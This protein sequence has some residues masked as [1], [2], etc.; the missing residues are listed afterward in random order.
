MVIDLTGS[1]EES[2]ATNSPT[3][4]SNTRM[5]EARPTNDEGNND[6][7]DPTNPNTA[8]IP[9]SNV[10]QQR[11]AALGPILE[12]DV[13]ASRR[14]LLEDP[15]LRYVRPTNGS[16]ATQN[17]SYGILRL[18]QAT[19][20]E[21]Y[22][23][24]N[25]NSKKPTLA[26]VSCGA[27]VP[28]FS[29]SRRQDSSINTDSNSNTNGEALYRLMN[30]HDIRKTSSGCIAKVYRTTSSPNMELCGC[31]EF[32]PDRNHLC[33]TCEHAECHHPPVPTEPAYR[34]QSLNGNTYNSNELPPRQAGRPIQPNS[35]SAG[36]G[37][38]SSSN[39]SLHIS[40]PVLDPSR[41]ESFHDPRYEIQRG[42]PI[43]QRL[44]NGRGGVMQFQSIVQERSLGSRG[45]FDG[46]TRSS[47]VQRD[48]TET[49]QERNASVGANQRTGG[50]DEI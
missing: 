6:P 22:G 24:I 47:E 5:P 45:E 23:K 27:P 43:P 4:V 14:R 39:S 8:L 15:N 50:M 46:H 44:P 9:D 11:R 37:S 35:I 30:F 12:E 36:G 41:R 3:E 49:P 33:I 18:S 10:V 34:P 19:N 40:Y 29:I 31:K 42:T 32:F 26:Q 25:Y 21:R 17:S 28:Q 2:D 1:D 13:D 7:I 16:N 20:L 38:R 48:H